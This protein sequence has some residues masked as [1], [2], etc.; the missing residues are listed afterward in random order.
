M[1]PV[2][3]TVEEKKYKASFQVTGTIEQLKKLKEFLT[4]GGFEYEQH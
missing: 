2:V 1:P 3:A 4:N